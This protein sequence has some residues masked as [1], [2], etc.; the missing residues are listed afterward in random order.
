MQIKT[1]GFF[2]CKL[3]GHWFM[4]FVNICVVGLGSRE[5]VTVIS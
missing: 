3:C 2:D 5:I 4:P 1:A